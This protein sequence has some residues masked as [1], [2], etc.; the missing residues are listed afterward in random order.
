[1]RRLLI[2]GG[3]LAAAWMLGTASAGAETKMERP[4]EAPAAERPAEVGAAGAKANGPLTEHREHQVDTEKRHTPRPTAEA[5]ASAAPKHRS[6]T[7]TVRS[8][9]ERAVRQVPTITPSKPQTPAGDAKGRGHGRPAPSVRD[10]VEKV[11]HAGLG[12]AEKGRAALPGLP[13]KAE[14]PAITRPATPR[15]ADHGPDAHDAQRP[16]PAAP[17]SE[18]E[19]KAETDDAPTAA[20]RTDAAFPYPAAD[21]SEGAWETAADGTTDAD[22]TASS[23]SRDDGDA[24][25]TAQ[26]I[27]GSAPQAQG[28]TAMPMVAGYLPATSLAAPSSG[29]LQADRHALAAIPQDPAEEPTV[30]PD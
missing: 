6:V 19:E 23:A 20:V 8:V 14:E 10:V 29:L 13:G 7:S 9:G 5:R 24:P 3:F 16:E 11:G 28:P 27:V 15:P 25:P 12:A 2:T 18:D 30:S 4:A 21:V 26:R 1:M 17:A 22:T